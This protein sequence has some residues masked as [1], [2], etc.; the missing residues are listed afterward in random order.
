MLVTEFLR[1]NEIKYCPLDITFDNN[2]KVKCFNGKFKDYKSFNT[3]SNSALVD[4]QKRNFTC[5]IIALNT[6]DITIL[7]IDNLELFE[8]H[9]PQLSK[10]LEES[11]IYYRSRNKRLPHYFLY[12]D[13]LPEDA[14]YR[15]VLKD[16]CADVLTGQWAWFKRDENIV[17]EKRNFIRVKFNDL[18]STQVVAKEA[19]KNVKS[20]SNQVIKESS[21]LMNLF[22]ESKYSNDS[23]SYYN[24][25][26][27]VIQLKAHNKYFCTL[28]NRE[29]VSN[30]NHPY[31]FEKENG[32]Y[33]GC[34]QNIVLLQSKIKEN[35]SLFTNYC[36]HEKQLNEKYL[37]YD[38]ET[39][40]NCDTIII[41][42]K[43]GTGKTTN[44]A[45][46]LSQYL[47]QH[48]NFKV[49][50]LVNY[51]SL[52]DQ[53][54]KTF[55]DQGI[56]LLNYQDVKLIDLKV[57]HS[58]CCINSIHKIQETD[59]SMVILYIDEITS[60]LK[61]LSE[62]QILDRNLKS[63]YLELIRI[64]KNCHKVIVSDANITD[65]V[66]NLLKHRNSGKEIYI[67]NLFKK[68]QN[69]EAIR[70]LDEVKFIQRL[71]NDITN[72]QM[73]LCGSDSCDIITKLYHECYS[74]YL[75]EDK[76]DKFILITSKSKFTITDPSKQFKNKWVFY[77][78]SIVTGIDFSIDEKQPQ[79]LYIK[80]E[81]LN[82]LDN[83]QQSTRTRN[84]SQLIYFMKDQKNKVQWQPL[85]EIEQKNKNLKTTSEQILNVCAGINENDETVIHENCYFKIAS[86]N[87][88]LGLLLNS[89][90]KYYFEYILLQNGFSLSSVNKKVVLSKEQII[91]QK[92]IQQENIDEYFEQFIINEIDHCNSYMVQ[93]ADLLGLQYE[94]EKIIRS[95]KDIICNNKIIGDYFNFIKY[96]KT[97]KY[98]DERIEMLKENTFNC[99]VITSI[100]YKI[101]L[102]REL[103]K[104]NKIEPFSD[105]TKLKKFDLPDTLFDKLVLT[106][107]DRQ[108]KP[109]TLYEFKKYYIGLLKN[110]FSKLDFIESHKEQCK[111]KRQYEYYF[112]ANLISHYLMLH[113]YE[114]P[115]YAHFDQRILTHFKVHVKTNMFY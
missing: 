19:I 48:N 102:V 89:D 69:V 1:E 93:N 23:I 109:A 90:R 66:R 49:L 106:F 20:K 32:Y 76:D 28:C 18:I 10:T 96:C 74:S 113:K 44:T 35:I 43:A 84:M 54:M 40:A 29:H 65:N 115:Y 87:E 9:Y 55:K 83:Y 112:N 80:G 57:N 30:S 71:K 45:K 8:Q 78:P 108:T 73:F 86:Y 101:K 79:Y 11:C 6:F 67:N 42:S 22:L 7:D 92:Q 14:K 88:Y 12:I 25:N 70:E 107:K 37:D 77:S 114:N 16:G 81:S 5:G 62:N 3:I 75:L 59:M 104:L 95:Y 56:T 27:D 98:I 34:R 58:V 64:I 110:M 24:I 51:I 26:Q 2:K 97:D 82:V 15:Y 60:F 33:F 39:F 36:I 38:Y 105:I 53:Q 111:G 94:N 85:E 99:K 46:Q 17:I 52:A 47:K 4:L 91:E 100:E 61:N 21:K 31:L 63:I 13:D 68:F 72:N 50:S 103:E 41:N